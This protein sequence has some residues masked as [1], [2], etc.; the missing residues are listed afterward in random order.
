MVIN[1]SYVKLVI[2]KV[3]LVTFC[4]DLLYIWCVFV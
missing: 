2:L 3:V 4:V 1:F